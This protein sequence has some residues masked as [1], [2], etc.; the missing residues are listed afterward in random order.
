MIENAHA[1]AHKMPPEI[2]AAVVA[3]MGKV[4]QIGKDDENKFAKYSYVSVD[5][6][7]DHIGRLMADAGIFVVADEA[8]TSVEVRET[9][10]DYGK[11]RKSNWL[12]C[13]YEIRLYHQSGACYGPLARSV[14]VQASG[15]QAY[16]SAQSYVEKYFLRSLF[17]VP[18]GEADADADAQ[19]GLPARSTSKIQPRKPEPAPKPELLSEEDSDKAKELMLH[20]LNMCATREELHDW[21]RANSATKNRLT[22]E[23]QELVSSA[24]SVRQ[25]AIKNQKDAA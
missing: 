3:V 2:A 25:H 21:A 22:K 19:E 5:K 23:D 7:F 10:D 1:E 13:Q 11:V 17:K 8:S 16:G 24:F 15:P 6:F 9:V 18:T 20:A 12:V 4:K 14:Q